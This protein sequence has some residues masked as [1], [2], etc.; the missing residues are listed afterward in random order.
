MLD[1]INAWE[2]KSIVKIQTAAEKARADLRQIHQ[3]LEISCNFRQI[4]DELR[5]SRD[6]DNYSE[7][8][9][10]RWMEK[11]QLLRNEL[12]MPTR[13]KIE[14]KEGKDA[15]NLIEICQINV[16]TPTN[17]THER[18]DKVA[19]NITL[20]TDHITATTS[21][22]IGSRCLVSVRGA[23]SYS[24]GLHKIYFEIVNKRGNDLFFGVIPSIQPL[25]IDGS[26][27]SST[28]GWWDVEYLVL[29]DNSPDYH[30][31]N[32]IKTGDIIAVTLNCDHG[33]ISYIVDRTQQS[34]TLEI[35]M[36]SCPLPWNLLIIMC[37]TGDSV[38]LLSDAPC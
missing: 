9:L 8:D 32:I 35:N 38:R 10:N 3:Q 33:H 6:L 24:S 23:S 18:F 14:Q 12:E 16:K 21:D 28:N 7:V 27:L 31:E 13:I 11:L 20:S 4:S 29:E 37:C 36:N 19:G 22:T 26:S 5:S 17:A 30:S 1:R 25:N 34:K 2:K 15:I